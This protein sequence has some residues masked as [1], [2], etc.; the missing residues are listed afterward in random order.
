MQKA[1][2]REG[3]LAALAELGWT[4]RVLAHKVGVTP[5]SVTNWLKGVDFPRPDKL[6]KLATALGLGFDELV[7]QEPDNLPIVA[8][9]KKAGAKTTDQHVLN[10]QGIGYLLGPLVDYLPDV[11]SLRSAI[12]S[13]SMEYG[14][15]QG[16][17]S[18]VRAKLGVGDKAVLEY[19]QLISEF[20][21]CGAVLVPVLW[22]K[23][24]NHK[25][26]LHIFLPKEDATFVFV[27]LDT[28][29]E[30]FKFW[31][32]HE[33]AH[34]LTPGLSGTVQG[35]DFA[36]AFAGTLLFPEACAEVAYSE[37]VG[38]QNVGR[39]I[40]VLN[41]HA[42]HHSI[43]LL[44]VYLQVKAFAEAKSLP[45]VR[46][47]EKTIHAVRNGID[48]TLVSEAIFNPMPP[49]PA[50]YIAAS[51]N[52]F[53]SDFFAALERMINERGTGISYVSQVLDMSL[54]DATG[55]HQE[56]AS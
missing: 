48:S 51:K 4:Q 30:D 20:K 11:P 29:L 53:H 40:D 21:S 47:P 39:Q 17:A 15:L 35:E 27:N 6:L 33:L 12:S 24:Q 34:V 46:I 44:T 14:R 13:P 2:H 56:L 28:K 3:L 50:Q 42:S 26:A 16:I 8:F 1:I 18:E 49:K 45:A 52:I 7:K 55:I 25:N 36:D 5:Q 32:S 10:A 31:M 22:G 54:R 37:L 38:K 41:Q 23:K 9:R 19:E 43:S